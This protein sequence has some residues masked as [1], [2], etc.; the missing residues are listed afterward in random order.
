[1]S[2]KLYSSALVLGFAA[3]LGGC[4]GEHVT[5]GLTE[6]IRIAGAQFREGELPGERPPT[7]DEINEGAEPKLP[8]V[9]SP[10]FSTPIIHSREAGRG[11]SGLAS[12][13]SGA[14]GV[15]LEGLGTGYWLLPTGGVDPEADNAVEWRF[16]ASF[17]EGLPTGLR[18]IL[19]T[20]FGKDGEAGTKIG[21]TLCVLPE[22]PD[23]NNACDPT[24][25]PPHTV[26]SLAWDAPVDLDLRVVTP[27]G[28]VVT[29]KHPSTAEENEDGEVDPTAEGVGNLDFDSFANCTDTGRQ[30]E[31]LVFQTKPPRGT[32]LVYAGLFDACG[33]HGVGYSVSIHNTAARQNGEGREP[34]ETYRQAGQLSAVHADGG[35]KLGTFVTSFLVK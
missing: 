3:V 28:K 22:I 8:F 13:G 18:Q 26:V 20:A 11:F 7:E 19:F 15:R 21:L 27:D 9:F 2:R 23:N 35:T 12:P 30:R 1:M 14:I 10:T 32:Y 25:D 24:Q 34:V 16:R 6:P 17:G 31:N 29:P 33:E 5:I 4:G